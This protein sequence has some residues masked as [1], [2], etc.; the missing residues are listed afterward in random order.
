L[1]FFKEYSLDE[2]LVNILE[3]NL[4]GEAFIGLDFVGCQN[5][6]D[7]LILDQDE[8]LLVD[9]ERLSVVDQVLGFVEL[10]LGELAHLVQ[11]WIAERRRELDNQTDEVIY[12][13]P[14][15][16]LGVVILPCIHQVLDVIT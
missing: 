13:N 11:F 14:P 10:L 3:M 15:S 7:V 16:G 2:D 5:S 1:E 9:V 12:V 8:L 4:L 6:E